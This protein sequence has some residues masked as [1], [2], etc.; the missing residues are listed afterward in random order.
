M[1]ILIKSE[2]SKDIKINLPMAAVTLILRIVNILPI[3]FDKHIDESLN[4]IF[5]SENINNLI[6]G[7]KYLKK[8]HKGIVLVDI[9]SSNGDKVKIE[10]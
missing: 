8:C 5:K 3:K 10:I 9:D 1:K 4:N 7:L 6:K 2:S